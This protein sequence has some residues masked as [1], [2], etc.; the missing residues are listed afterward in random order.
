MQPTFTQ[1]P[2][3]LRSSTTATR[4]PK[5]AESRLARV[6]PQPPPPPSRA[7]SYPLLRPAPPPPPSAPCPPRGQ[8]RRPRELWSAADGG[9][10]VA[11]DEAQ[12]VVA[13]EHA[14]HV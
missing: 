13:L 12:R 8:S 10:R 9:G 6:P 14:V 3:S 5:P 7:K 1:V 11:E 2:P 4:A